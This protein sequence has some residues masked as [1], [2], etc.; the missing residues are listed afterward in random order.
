MRAVILG[1]GVV[2]TLV[3]QRLVAQGA[4][5]VGSRRTPWAQEAGDP[6][7]N[8]PVLAGGLLPVG[9]ADAV[10]VAANPG[11]R[12]GRDNGVAD[13]VRAASARWPATRL[14][15][16]STTSLY[17]DAEGAGLAEDGPLAPTPEAAALRALEIA[18]EAHADHLVLR[19]TA[20]VGPTRTFARRRAQAARAAGTS[21]VVAGDPDRPFSY[22][23]DDDLAD[24]AVEALHGAYGRGLLN[25]ACP[26]RLTVRD[27][28]TAAAGGPVEV[29]SDGSPQPR[30][31]IDAGRWWALRNEPTWRAL[32][33]SRRSG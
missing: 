16:I 9:P 19:A 2:G 23:H 7:P 29:L 21:V 31:W 10:L 3:G 4:T 12:R 25:A 30:R 27:Y 15:L 14:V 13:L 18:A 8:F 28:Y 11:I 6:V 20:L 5:V 17:G 32:D 24:L 1:C 33:G 26:H 22:L